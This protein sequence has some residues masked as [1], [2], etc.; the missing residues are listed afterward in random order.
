M[1]P[2]KKAIVALT[3]ALFF[4][5]AVPYVV[6]SVQAPNGWAVGSA[7]CG[8]IGYMF[9]ALCFSCPRCNAPLLWEIRNHQKIGRLIPKDNCTECG[10]PLNH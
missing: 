6:M 1:V 10:L 3:V 5:I 2:Q 9:W 7:L 8:A 4:L